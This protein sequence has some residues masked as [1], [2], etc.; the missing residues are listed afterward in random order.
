MASLDACLRLLQGP[1]DEQ[2][3]AG[4]LMVTKFLS[5]SDLDD[6]SVQFGDAVVVNGGGGGD[7]VSVRRQLFD[8]I[9]D[10]F[11]KRLLKTSDGDGGDGGSLHRNLALSVISTFVADEY[12]AR[13]MRSATPVFLK[14]LRSG[15]QAPSPAASSTGAPVRPPP[16][17]PTLVH[18]IIDALRCLAGVLHACDDV[19]EQIGVVKVA[20]SVVCAASTLAR[21]PGMPDTDDI[22]R[23]IVQRRAANKAAAEEAL[24]KKTTATPGGSHGD[25]SGDD[26]A[27][28]GTAVAATSAANPSGSSSGSS[29]SSSR[30]S[31]SGSSGQSASGGGDAATASTSPSVGVG[32]D[33]GSGVPPSLPEDIVQSCT[34]GLFLARR[35]ILSSSFS[36]AAGVRRVS[37]RSSS[38]SSTSGGTEAD[39]VAAIAGLLVH[40]VPEVSLAALDVLRT[41]MEVPSVCT[42]VFNGACPM[43]LERG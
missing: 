43:G 15:W 30:S 20:A 41:A 19:V 35:V 29:N 21:A 10:D 27:D 39:F 32:S 36:S 33:A 6:A 14:V 4:L 40:V 7:A 12:V 26:D 23:G 8:A 16:T 1:S 34:S 22:M 18:A 25:G 2:R 5:V 17:P 3:F 31:G 9:G 38:G 24:R 37:G 42:A 28:D 13:R 11:L